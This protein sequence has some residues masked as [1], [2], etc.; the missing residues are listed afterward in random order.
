MPV[1]R[2]PRA[3]DDLRSGGLQFEG[4]VDRGELR[5]H[6]ALAQII[7][8]LREPEQERRIARPVKRGVREILPRALVITQGERKPAKLLG[9]EP[10]VRVELGASS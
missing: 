8:S 10:V 7:G 3:G 5:L 9:R 2:R 6:V 4:P 1:R